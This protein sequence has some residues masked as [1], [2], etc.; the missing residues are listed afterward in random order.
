MIFTDLF[1][2]DDMCQSLPFKT[3]N[4]NMPVLHRT[5][6]GGMDRERDEEKDTKG[7][8]ESELDEH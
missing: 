3:G 5:G 8:K 7:G 6:L 1:F 2:G 4:F